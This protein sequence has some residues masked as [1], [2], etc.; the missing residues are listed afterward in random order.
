MQAFFI[1]SHLLGLCVALMLII[2]FIQLPKVGFSSG[3][4]TFVQRNISFCV[5]FVNIS[6]QTWIRPN[7]AGKWKHADFIVSL[8]VIRLCENK[9][10]NWKGVWSTVATQ[11]GAVRKS[12]W[13]FVIAANVRICGFDNFDT[14]WTL[15][16]WSFPGYHL[17]TNLSFKSA[18]HT[19]KNTDFR[20]FLIGQKVVKCVFLL[21][22][23]E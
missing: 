12:F 8:S 10:L 16:H 14:E 20:V 3:F 9:L 11:V 17:C 4:T 6:T 22:F 15:Q 7:E 13:S 21:P 23:R 2:Q 19:L 1:F 18:S 5:F